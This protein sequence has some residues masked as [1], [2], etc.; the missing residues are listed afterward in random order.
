MHYGAAREVE[1]THGVQPAA[2]TPNPVRQRVVHEGGPQQA[3]Q[4]EGLEPLALG[5]GP[6]DQ[7]RGDHGKHHLKDHEGL[8]GDR[9][10]I[11]R[12]G[13]EPDAV[14]AQP[15]QAA[16][17]AVY[18]QVA[19]VAVDIRPKRQA[20]AP[21]HPLDGDQRQDEEAVHDGG[22]HVLRA[23]QAPVEE[24]QRRRHQH[25]QGCRGE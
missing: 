19:D 7:R 11:G 5:E 20:V 1:R 15:G 10:R 3:E 25:D 24:A 22:E 17:Q 21:Q 13:R 6:R 23:H 18:I 14:Q 12:V 2:R 9:R 16:D 8:V 4:H